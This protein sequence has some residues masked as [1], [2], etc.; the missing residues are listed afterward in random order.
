M[1]ALAAS[2]RRRIAAWSAVIA[3]SAANLFLHIHIS[4]VCDALYRSLGR[5]TYEWVTLGGIATLSLGGVAVLL[6]RRVMRLGTPPALAIIAALALMTVAAQQ[7]LLVSNVELIHFPQ[8]ALVG[9][10]I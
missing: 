7:A 5:V 1:R 9:A 4:N 10:L 3:V 6:G 2:S 8:F